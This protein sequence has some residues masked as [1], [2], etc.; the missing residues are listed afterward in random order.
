MIIS[1]LSSIIY[2]RTRKFHPF[3][4]SR[5]LNLRSLLWHKSPKKVAKNYPE[6]YPPKQKMLRLVILHLFVSQK[7]KLFGI[8][9][10]LVPRYF[11][12]I[13]SLM[14]VQILCTRT[15]CEGG[16]FPIE[17]CYCFE[18]STMSSFSGKSTGTIILYSARTEKRSKQC[19]EQPKLKVS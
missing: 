2:L 19:S 10:P 8:K 11:L 14:K 6:H 4:L 5:W 3:Q 16:H 12:R 17:F 13:T 18:N 7:E 15:Y 1:I 9:L